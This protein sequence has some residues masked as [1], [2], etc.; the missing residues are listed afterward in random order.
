MRVAVY[1]DFQY[2]EANGDV[3]GEH[4]FT[5]FFVA[6]AARLERVVLLGRLDPGSGRGR[7]PL[8]ERL[9]FVPLPFYESLTHGAQF[10]RGIFVSLARF[11][12]VLG[13]VECVWLLGPHPLQLGFAA[14]AALRGRRVVLGVRQDFPRYVASRHPERPA[15]RLAAFLLERAWRTLALVCGVV[16]VGPELADRYRRSKRLLQITASLVSERDI[17]EPSRALR[18]RH[19]PTFTVLSVGRLETEKNPLILADV[20]ARLRSGGDPWRLAVC[21]EGPLSS[22]LHARI[23]ELGLDS[24]ADLLGY[25]PNGPALMSQYRAAD[26]FLHASW[27]E[28]LPQV[29]F[30]AFAAALPVVATDVGGVRE[31]VGD[32]VVLVPP[33]DPSSAASA[34]AAVAAD[35]ASRRRLVEAGHRHVRARTI[36]AE[37]DRVAAFLAVGDPSGQAAH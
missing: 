36:D 30:E 33:G 20:L 31:A 26:V 25:V 14:M 29:L 3:S 9:E 32:A 19:D 5:L 18:R 1:T 15:F 16:V 11:W 22:D 27:T 10:I 37:A 24:D 35:P 17:V 12:R 28:G 13:Q 34:I 8:G 21:G 4:A 7:Y 2:H 23:T 6:L